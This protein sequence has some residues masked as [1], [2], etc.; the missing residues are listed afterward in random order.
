MTA[1]GNQLNLVQLP[2]KSCPP[3][4]LARSYA[5]YTERMLFHVPSILS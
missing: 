3:Q 1:P 4:I 5:R 2:P